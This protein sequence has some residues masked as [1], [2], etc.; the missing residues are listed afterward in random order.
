MQDRFH[1]QL[2]ETTPRLRA[3][4]RGLTGTADQAEDLVQEASAR[5]LASRHLFTEGTNF[6]AWMFTI[7]RNIHLNELRRHHARTEP[8]DAAGEH[9]TSI[10]ASQER[11]VEMS[12]VKTAL[13]SLPD[14]QQ[15][16]LL[17]VGADGRSV[18][19]VARLCGCA[20]GTVK[21]RVSRARTALSRRLAS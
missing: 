19:E 16:A 12:D 8:L 7:L 6:R 21:S 9:Q 1:E 2:V 5:A 14:E 17:L 4:A 15:R 13:A 20:A 18:D 10:A 3:F 11:R